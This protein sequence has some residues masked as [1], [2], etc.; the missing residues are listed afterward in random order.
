MLPALSA[1]PAPAQTGRR[2]RNVLLVMTDGLRWQ[3][4]FGGIDPALI[5]KESGA[6]DPDALRR[7]YWRDTPEARRQVLMPFL[8]S[9]IARQGQ[10]FGNRAID[11]EVSVT[12][13]MNFSYP[14][15]SETLCGFADPRIDSNDKVPNPNVTVFEWLHRKPGYRG[16][17]AAFGAWDVFPFIFHADRA[18]FPVN[19][20]YD[21]LTIPPVSERIEFLNHLKA[22]SRVWEDEAFDPFTF[23]TA[24]EYVRQ[25]KPLVLFLSLGET[26]EWAHEGKYAAYLEATRRVD[27]EVEE[28]WK[29]VQSLDEYRGTTT[30]IFTCDHGRG[31]APVEWRDHGQKIPD[32]KYIWMAFLGPDT[33]ALGERRHIPPLHQ[34]QIGATLAAFLGEDYRA[35]VPQAG[36]PIDAV[37]GK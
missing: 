6:G 20:G 15:Y 3:E 33:P 2:T 9:T 36:T 14:G 19:A 18:G 13:G 17:I 23:H 31:Q 4:V 34:N 37:L 22:E 11:S 28:L 24:L 29:T 26:D 35:T 32:S 10:I 25:H 1:L 8:W 5:N 21:P 27:R 7:E 16:R 12:N 30:L